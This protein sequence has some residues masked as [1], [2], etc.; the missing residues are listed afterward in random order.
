MQDPLVNNNFCE[1]YINTSQNK[2]INMPKK[3]TYQWELYTKLL[4]YRTW[5]L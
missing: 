1:D 5:T 2:N 4:A 3:I